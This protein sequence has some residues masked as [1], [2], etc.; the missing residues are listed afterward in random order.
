[1]VLTTSSATM[2]AAHRRMDDDAPKEEL[3]RPAVHVPTH[4]GQGSSPVSHHGPMTRPLGESITGSCGTSLSGS[5]VW[6]TTRW[7]RGPSRLTTAQSSID[8]DA[9]QSH[10]T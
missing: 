9:G 3:F 4:V 6:S 1:M 10:W 8:P 5:T 7:I 2:P